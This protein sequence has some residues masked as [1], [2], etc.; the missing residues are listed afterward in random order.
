[1]GRRGA[2]GASFKPLT[3]LAGG[4][5]VGVVWIMTHLLTRVTGGWG[6]N[7]E[8]GAPPDMSYFGVTLQLTMSIGGQLCR[9]AP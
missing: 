9:A 4:G 2:P 6:V 3:V 5:P 8:P 7:P 1:M